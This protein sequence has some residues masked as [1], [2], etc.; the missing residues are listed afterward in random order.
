MKQKEEI[1]H[2]QVKP[3]FERLAQFDLDQAAKETG[4]LCRT[5]RKMSPG[6]L[7][8]IFTLLGAYRTAAYQSCSMVAAVIFRLSVSKQGIWK[9]VQAP[10]VNFLK[11]VL[12]HLL[13]RE[14][15][16]SSPEAGLFDHFRRVLIQDS[17]CIN[18]PAKLMAFYPGSGNGNSSG[19][20]RLKIQATLDLKIEKFVALTLTPF[21][22][23]DQTAAADVLE[24]IHPN[25]LVIRD[26][27]YFGLKVF[28]AMIAAKAFFLTRLPYGM[29]LSLP[30]GNDF[31]LLKML[32]RHQCLDLQLLAGRAE[33]L[34]LR[35]V[36]LPVPPQI[37]EQRRRKLR[38]H[39]KTE[40][41]REPEHAH[42][43]LLG[44]EIFLTNV[45]PSVWSPS[46]AASAYGCRWR[47]ENIFKRW[48]SIFQINL[49]PPNAS[50]H[51]TEAIIYGRL[52]YIICIQTHFSDPLRQR[53]PHHL[54]PFKTAR[55]FQEHLLLGLLCPQLISHITSSPTNYATFLQYDKRRRRMNF[56]QILFSFGLR[57]SSYP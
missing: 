16:S 55:F 37:A 11:T 54:S 17:T 29:I 56:E 25:D 12:E 9:R 31:E 13:C 22:R 57:P 21:R 49:I 1:N 20:A 8:A 48:K 14:V 24:I 2:P 41:K 3:L 28:R 15:K 27:G 30:D 51:Q 19:T 53:S 23:T 39:K 42:M 33:K 10:L 32:R 36:A 35:L 4:L 46:Q 18:L 26:L 43:A 47:I 52:I 50:R 45:P 5:P 6:M 44:W 40:S 34:P 7:L 38:A